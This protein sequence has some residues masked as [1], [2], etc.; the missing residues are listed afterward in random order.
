MADPHR[1]FVHLDVQSAFSV[2][3]TCPTLPEDYVR[4]LLR[5]Y[6]IGPDSQ[7]QPRPALAMADYGLH[8]A[9]KTAVACARAGVDHLVGL[10]ARVVAE[11]AFR[12]W[13]EQPRELIL[14]AADDTGWLN[15]VLL[16]NI[17]QLSGGDWRGPRLDWDDLAS[18]GEGLICLAGGPPSVGL[19]RRA[20]SRPKIPTNLSRRCWPRA[21][22][23]TF[24]A[25]GC[26][27][28]CPSTGRRRT[29]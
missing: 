9:V 13:S 20:S 3:G 18:H 8:S 12:P 24:M 11:R 29:R 21:G 10:R 16:S 28:R 26:M 22:W 17:G 14:L 2:A 27:W 15:M 7:E 19:L 23:R 1:P 4:A 6:P 5:H 25:I